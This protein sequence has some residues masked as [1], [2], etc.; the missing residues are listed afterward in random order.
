MLTENLRTMWM[1]SLSFSVKTLELNQIRGI[2]AH[3]GKVKGVS[4]SQNRISLEA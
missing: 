4:A 1:D 3:L 2:S